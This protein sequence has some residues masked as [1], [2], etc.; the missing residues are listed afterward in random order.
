MTE[1]SSTLVT[2]IHEEPVVSVNSTITGCGDPFHDQRGFMDAMG[3]STG[4][5]HAAQVGLYLK[6]TAEEL[7]ETIS[8]ANPAAASRLKE[9][10]TEVE[11]LCVVEK[12]FNEVELFDGLQ[13]V[14]V[15]T[16]GAGISANFPMR[17]GWDAV[18]QTNLAKVDPETGK[19]RR[20]ADGKVL[21]PEG[22]VS[23]TERLTALLAAH[24]AT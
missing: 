18:L 14:L 1:T 5:F 10:F 11:K 8:A 21:K 23:P 9:L 17:Q 19:V 2:T 13:D 12:D 15:T 24:R 20:R 22:W 16:I 3:Q 7:C 6:L 4:S